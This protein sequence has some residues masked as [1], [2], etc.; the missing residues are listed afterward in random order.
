[1]DRAAAAALGD[2]CDA[3][4][5]V[6]SA[7]GGAPPAPTARPA[8]GLNKGR[9]GPGACQTNP[10]GAK[11]PLSRLDAGERVPLFAFD[12]GYDSAQLTLDLAEEQVAGLVRLRSDCCFYADPLDRGRSLPTRALGCPARRS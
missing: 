3:G 1:M 11:R 2:G 12:G 7:A 10:R 9:F 4:G 8:R 5:R 6:G